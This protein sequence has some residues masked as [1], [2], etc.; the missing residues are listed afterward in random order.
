MPSF[1]T[2]EICGYRMEDGRIFCPE[3]APNFSDIGPDNIVTNR[4]LP[5]QEAEV[6]FCDECGSLIEEV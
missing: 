4:D 3:H 5:D 6:F 2:D 1:K